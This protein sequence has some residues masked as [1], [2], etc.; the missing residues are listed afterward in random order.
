MVLT[1][2]TELESAIEND[3]EQI[4]ELTESTVRALD[5]KHE[6]ID[7]QAQ[8]IRDAGMIGAL[9]NEVNDAADDLLE[10][11]IE[12]NNA[13]L[14][15]NE[16]LLAYVEGGGDDA[17][18]AVLE[19][20]ETAIESFETY[21][22]VLE[23][24]STMDA[25]SFPPMVTVEA[26]DDKLYPWMDSVSVPVVL[27]NIGNE[28]ATNVELNFETR[29]EFDATLGRSSI[30]S[31]A[32]DESITI[33]L[34][35]TTPEPGIVKVTL[36]LE[37]DEQS[38]EVSF[39]VTFAGTANALAM[40]MKELRELYATL[41]RIDSA[42]STNWGRGNGNGS[43][44]GPDGLPS[45][46]ENRLG[47][48]IKQLTKCFLLTDDGQDPGDKLGAVSNKLDAFINQVDGLDGQHINP[49]NA[50]RLRHDAS[51]VQQLIE[52]AL[53]AEG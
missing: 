15:V 28:S 10:A 25:F 17:R 34:E 27:T 7:R 47:A 9:P 42:E 39:H 24:L 20:A 26:S 1:Q 3:D 12:T 8:Y 35:G 31:L 36:F 6:T 23:D 30:A 11:S 33:Q 5:K 52:T 50:E 46:L 43:S 44:G 37:S 19:A 2:L 18:N 45:G 49:A 53:D 32:P 22:A 29:G 40:A 41:R 21:D 13:H 51:S 38:D 48:T 14:R 16:T 4:I